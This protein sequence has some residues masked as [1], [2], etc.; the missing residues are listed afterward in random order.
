MLLYHEVIMGLVYTIQSTSGAG[1]SSWT[2]LLGWQIEVIRSHFK[3]NSMVLCHSCQKSPP[4]AWGVSFTPSSDR[5]QD[6]LLIPCIA[7]ALGPATCR[8]MLTAILACG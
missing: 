2:P 3:E 1:F 6:L 7:V 5:C 4:D 8:E